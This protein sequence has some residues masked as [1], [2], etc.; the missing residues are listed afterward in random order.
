MPDI[1]N[2]EH[3]VQSSGQLIALIA[4]F[5]IVFAETGLLIGFFPPRR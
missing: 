4:L 2:V 1:F 5:G 3:F